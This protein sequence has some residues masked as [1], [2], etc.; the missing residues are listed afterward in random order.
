MSR[1][2]LA[3]AATLTAAALVPVAAATPAA[4]EG[5][6]A[7]AGSKL[8][9]RQLV[10]AHGHD[11]GR[12]ELWYRVVSGIGFNCVQTVSSRPGNTQQGLFA[13]LAVS[14][15]NRPSTSTTYRGGEDDGL[16]RYYAGGVWMPA[17]NRCVKFAGRVKTYLSGAIHQA[18]HTT[19]WGWCG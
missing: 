17:G 14:T 12:V 2:R 4:A 5:G 11:L 13:A 7:C 6:P 10:D 15:T 16:Y 8:A 18:Q 3:L 1:M 19:G 9:T